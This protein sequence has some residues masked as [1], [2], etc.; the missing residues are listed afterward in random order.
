M[1]PIFD[2]DGTLVDSLEQHARF[3]TDF[4][5]SKGIRLDFQEIVRSIQNPESCN[6]FFNRIGIP[7]ELIPE[8]L[9]DYKQRFGDYKQQPFPGIID[10]VRKVKQAEQRVS[11]ATYNFRRNILSH[12]GDLIDLFDTVVTQDDVRLKNQ[13]L[14]RIIDRYGLPPKE[15]TLIGDTCWDYDSSQE[16]GIG[17]IGVSWG[18]HRLAKNSKYPVTETVP[19]LEREIF[20]RL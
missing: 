2:F 18:W 10:L 6:N 5:R 20:Q 8:L 3:Y 14:Q 19:E 13:G 15:F 4:A 17:F 9:G 11:L 12:G 7:T 1:I 16:A